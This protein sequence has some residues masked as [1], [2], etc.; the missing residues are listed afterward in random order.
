MRFKTYAAMESHPDFDVEARLDPIDFN[1]RVHGSC[2]VTVDSVSVDVGE[3]PIRVAIPFLKR[4]AKYPV[5][6]SVGGFRIA[7]SPFRVRTKGMTVQLE[8][9]LGTKGIVG[10]MNGKI[11][12]K[13]EMKADGKLV[14]RVG[15]FT[16]E[17]GEDPD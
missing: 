8:G 1:A 13:T 10:K 11:D 12:C 6:A 2:E 16:V 15:T 3:I 17:L 7:F 9:V 5:L 14:G 4:R